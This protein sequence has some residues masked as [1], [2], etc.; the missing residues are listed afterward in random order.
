MFKAAYLKAAYGCA[1]SLRVRHSTRNL[2]DGGGLVLVGKLFDRI[3]WRA[4]NAKVL[5]N[6][7][8]AEA[9]GGWSR[10]AARSYPRPAKFPARPPSKPLTATIR[11]PP[12]APL[13]STSSPA[14]R[15]SRIGRRRPRLRGWRKTGEELGSGVGGRQPV[16][17]PYPGR[18]THS[19]FT[20]SSLTP[21]P[22]PNFNPV[23][24]LGELVRAR[25]AQAVV[26]MEPEQHQPVDCQEAVGDRVGELVF[27]KTQSFQ[28]GEIAELGRDRTAELVVGK[29]QPIQ[30]GEVAE[31][32][33][34]RAGQL[35]VVKIQARQVGEVAELGRDRTG[36]LVVVKIQARQ[37]AR[38]RWGRRSK[39]RPWPSRSRLRSSSSG[40]GRT[41][42]GAPG[43][44][45]RRGRAGG[46]WRDA[47]SS[48]NLSWSYRDLVDTFERW[49]S[50]RRCH[51]GRDWTEVCA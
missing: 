11:P 21:R 28:V 49:I 1:R 29:E 16:E 45:R 7:S 10:P 44:R 6:R 43:S 38:P 14:R 37:V 31:L 4:T 17:P 5:W 47:S 34:D 9:V 40:P 46:G 41:R 35:V 22:L 3:L 51:H 12:A 18:T 42:T 25:R 23:E 33:R 15:R 26:V 8:G 19:R 24:P 20:F 32:G 48:W 30:L 27:V 39:T 13:N 50:T 36:Q 2:T